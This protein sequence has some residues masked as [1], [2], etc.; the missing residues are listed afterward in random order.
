[1]PWNV[2]EMSSRPLC[3]VSLPKCTPSREALTEV[4]E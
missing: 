2:V 4:L 1:L 3:T